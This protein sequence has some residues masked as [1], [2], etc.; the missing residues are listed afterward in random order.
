MSRSP[1]TADL[2]NVPEYQLSAITM[3][4]FAARDFSV[5]AVS[6]FESHFE[7][8]PCFASTGSQYP[9]SVVLSNHP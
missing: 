1:T 6:V 7:R 9:R 4:C 8:R 2:V 5:S 3:T